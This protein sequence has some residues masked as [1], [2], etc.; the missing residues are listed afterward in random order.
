M[1]N[2]NLDEFISLIINDEINHC[3]ENDFKPT[4]NYLCTEIISKYNIINSGLLGL[5]FQKRESKLYLTIKN[6]I[7]RIIESKN[8]T[9]KT[10]ILPQYYYH[11]T[12]V[13]YAILTKFNPFSRFCELMSNLCFKNSISFIEYNEL[14][15]IEINDIK[16]NGV[17]F[18]FIA[19]NF[20][21][22]GMKERKV[23]SQRL[24]NKNIKSVNFL[25]NESQTINEIPLKLSLKEKIKYREFYREFKDNVYLLD[26]FKDTKFIEEQLKKIKDIKE[27]TEC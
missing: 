14:T 1:P 21:P 11:Y 26:H 16:K 12:G 18:I 24:D 27:N 8:K 22:Y 19:T 20:S 7:L 5:N 10:S 4:I 17:N 2:E 13:N 15:S 3:L 25:I 23:L 9:L 6:S